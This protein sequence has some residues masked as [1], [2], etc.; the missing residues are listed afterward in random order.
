VLKLTLPG[1]IA[2]ADELR[3]GDGAVGPKWPW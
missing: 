2:L 3:N 1:L